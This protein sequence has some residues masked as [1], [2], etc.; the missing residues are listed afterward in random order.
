MPVLEISILPL[1]TK[2]ASVSSYVAGCVKILEKEKGI[3]Y[4]ITPM[5]TIIEARSLRKLFRVAEKMHKE[6][7]SKVDRVVTTIKIDDRKDK[8]LT[9]T[10]KISSVKKKL[11][12]LK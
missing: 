3:K 10:G 4:Q 12:T 11:K 5:E 6:V 9:M 2:T 8:K 1:G 7:L